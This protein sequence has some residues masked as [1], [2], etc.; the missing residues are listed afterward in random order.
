MAAHANVLVLYRN[1]LKYAKRM[2]AKKKVE[3]LALIKDGFRQNMDEMD[4][5][6]RRA[7]LEKAQSSLG[8]LKIVTPKFSSDKSND[9][10]SSKFA[11]GTHR[12]GRAVS[13]WTGSNMDPDSVSRHHNTLKR[14][15][16][17]G[18]RDV[19]GPLF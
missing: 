5:E 4:P 8:Y 6:A 18:N 19:I 10:S 3:T 12:P 9:G 17:K 2:P 1:M 14:A 11:S 7:Q 16:F 13:N 15:G